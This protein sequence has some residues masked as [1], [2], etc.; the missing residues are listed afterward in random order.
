MP[1]APQLI[2]QM[3]KFLTKQRYDAIVIDDSDPHNRYDCAPQYRFRSV[4]SGFPSSAGKLIITEAHSRL[5]LDARYYDAAQ[6]LIERAPLTIAR[7]STEQAWIASA[8]HLIQETAPR[9]PKSTPAHPAVQQRRRIWNV[10]VDAALISHKQYQRWSALFLENDIALHAQQIALSKQ[11]PIAVHT[12]NA[13]PFLLDDFNGKET[14]TMRIATFKENFRKQRLDYYISA[15]ADDICWL[16]NVRGFDIPYNTV[17]CSAVIVSKKTIDLYIEQQT[18][19]PSIRKRLIQAAITICDYDAFHVDLMKIPQN[20]RIGYEQENIRHALFNIISTTAGKLI[21]H[22][23]HT[24]RAIKTAAEISAIKAAA[25]AEGVALLQLLYAVERMHQRGTAIDE[26]EVARLHYTFRKKEPHFI[27][28]SFPTIVACGKNSAEMHYELRAAHASPLSASPLLLLDC[29]GHYY[30]GTTDITRVLLFGNPS[31]AMRHDYTK[32]LIAHITLARCR[33]PQGSSGSQLDAIGR[34]TL[35][36]WGEDFGHGTGHGIGYCLN[37]HDGVAAL[38]PK[39]HAPIE[40]G[41]LFSNEP[42][43]YRVNH[44][45]VRLESMIIA[46]AD[47]IKD[48]RG[49]AF[50]RFETISVFPFEQ[51]LMDVRMLKESDIDW[52]NNYHAFVYQQLAR[53]VSHAHRQWL[54]EKTKPIQYAR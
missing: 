38:T 54:A 40:A 21:P 14:R 28:E 16:I 33:F 48:A 18:L 43:L 34:S 22:Q 47:T 1:A 53:H 29:G 31:D 27:C 4:V 11:I 50:L 17:I 2:A 35:W 36:A 49:N 32:V 20:M 23:L 45:G 42:G 5:W 12:H 13:P 8:A 46:V 3:R 9:F 39:A 44:Y 41:M 15:A 19:T 37:V 26:V 7:Y 6:R 24:Q 52:I 51:A 25:R 30:T 10:V